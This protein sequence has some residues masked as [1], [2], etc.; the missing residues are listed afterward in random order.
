MCSTALLLVATLIFSVG[1]VDAQSNHP[2]PPPS[3]CD[4][5]VHQLHD[6]WNK[7][8]RDNTALTQQLE[9]ANEELKSANEK[10]EDLEKKLEDLQNTNVK[11]EKE[12]ETEQEKTKDMVVINAELTQVK[13]NWISSNDVEPTWHRIWVPHLSG[14][15]IQVRLQSEVS[16]VSDSSS[17]S[18]MNTRPRMEDCSGLFFIAVMT[19]FTFWQVSACILRQENWLQPLPNHAL[20]RHQPSLQTQS[21]NGVSLEYVRGCLMVVLFYFFMKACYSSYASCFVVTL[22]SL[23]VGVYHCQ[24]SDAMENIPF[25]SD[26]FRIYYVQYAFCVLVFAS[27]QVQVLLDPWAFVFVVVVYGVVFLVTKYH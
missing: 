21:E 22:T 15:L 11:L 8:D 13:N 26:K 6:N 1:C 3:A 19:F 23:L 5:W 16:K 27:V 14:K 10:L 24:N 9:T 25:I 17:T 12:L 18:H 2:D 4:Q 20:V 7:M